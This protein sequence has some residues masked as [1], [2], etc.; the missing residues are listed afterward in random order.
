MK[1]CVSPGLVAE[2]G[3]SLPGPWLFALFHTTAAFKTNYKKEF[4]ADLHQAVVFFSPA[5][6]EVEILYL[7]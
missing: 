1:D 5:M 6:S 7:Y 2:A 3:G 4:T